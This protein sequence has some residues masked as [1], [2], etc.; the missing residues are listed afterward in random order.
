MEPRHEDLPTI[1]HISRMALS[2]LL[3]NNQPHDVVKCLMLYFFFLTLMYSAL[4]RLS[5]SFASETLFYFIIIYV[6]FYYLFMKAFS[7]CFYPKRLTTISG[8]VST[9]AI[10]YEVPCSRA[11]WRSLVSRGITLFSCYTEQNVNQ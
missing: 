7:R 4:L 3:G 1:Q 2:N 9:I 11:Q 6:L 8:P 5:T 10:C